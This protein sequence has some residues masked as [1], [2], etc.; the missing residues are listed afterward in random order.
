MNRKLMI[1][2][3][4]L[5][6]VAIA[7]YFLYPNLL[8]PKLVPPKQERTILYWADPM[9]PGDRSDH[10]GKSPMGMDRVP[11][12]ETGS[13]A[14]AQ[15]ENKPREEYY[16]PMHPSVVHDRPGACDICG[17][18]LVKRVRAAAPG[19][20]TTS[21]LGSVLISPS[22]QILAQVATVV[23]ER[24]SAV[25]TIRASGRIEVA[26]PNFRHISTRFA[27]RIEK[28]YLTYTG[29][30]VGKGD[31]VADLYSPEA[32][33]A[34]QEYL[35]ASASY[36]EAK[37]SPELIASGALA[38][39]DQSRQ[40]LLLWGWTDA[41]I[42]LL[43]STR[44]V[45]DTVTITSPIR[46]TVLKKYFD[47]QHYAAAGEDMYDVADLSDVWM[48]ADVYESEIGWVSA[49]QQVTA[50]GDAFPGTLFTGKVGF[51]SPTVDPSARTVEVRAEFPNPGDRL[52]PGMYVNA[53]IRVPLPPAIVIPAGALLLTGNRSVV[54]VEADS[55][56]FRPRTVRAGTRAGDDIQILEG[57][58]EGDRIVASGGYLLDSESQLEAAS[59]NSINQ[60]SGETP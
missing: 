15:G 6:A 4:L 28:L 22:R 30:A 36:L 55:G 3:S 21:G 7:G 48:K 18:T 38:L 40:K 34:Q 10:P 23:A 19:R 47:P 41:Q 59:G 50:A 51:I 9:L 8:R 12:Y 49:G 35:L 54:W 33:S 56:V 26:E 45:R 14:A 29:Q 27:G 2:G 57:I 17:M 31:P 37:D 5:I 53:V 58:D 32:I 25:K 24:K 20:E 39:L 13:T 1:A 60:P 16:C 52:K 42:A 43:D 44:R 46:G 11:V